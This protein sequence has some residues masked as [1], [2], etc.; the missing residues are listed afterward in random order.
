MKISFGNGTTEYG[1]G[2]DIVLTG[3]EVA[4]A[5]GTWLVAHNVHI[6]GPRTITVNGDMC[7]KGNVYVDPSGFVVSDGEKFSGRGI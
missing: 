1:P 3:A 6:N 5:I 7:E 4:T 2:V